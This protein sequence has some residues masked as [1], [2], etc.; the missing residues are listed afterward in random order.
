MTSFI[1][2]IRLNRLRSRIQIAV[3]RNTGSAHLLDRQ[4]AIRDIMASLS[5]WRA[6]YPATDGN[7]LPACS[8]DFFEIEYHN[9]V[10][11][12]LRPIV[13][14][15]GCPRDLVRA[16]ASSAAAL[17]NVECNLLRKDPRNLAVWVLSKIFSR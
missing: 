3:Y 15:S 17:L 12:L 11:V 9:C 4:E 5:A 2:T 13:I 7:S 14:L 16:C 6:Q 8:S 10:Q 1:H